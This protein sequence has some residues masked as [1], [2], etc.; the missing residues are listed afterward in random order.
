MCK[1]VWQWEYSSQTAI[2]CCALDQHKGA[3]LRLNILQGESGQSADPGRVSNNLCHPKC[4]SD[5][6]V[7]CCA[8]S[9]PLL[10]WAQTPCKG[11]RVLN[12]KMCRG[13]VL[14]HCTMYVYTVCALS[15]C[16]SSRPAAWDSSSRAQQAQQNVQPRSD[17]PYASAR[18]VCAPS[19]CM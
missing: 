16:D 13:L 6:A 14:C 4:K 9:T 10:S 18:K 7:A 5:I 1:W 12:R 17:A 15:A 19:T 8:V 2:A 3:E 11:T